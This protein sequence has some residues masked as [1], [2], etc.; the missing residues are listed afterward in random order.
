MEKKGFK[1]H[2]ETYS[3]VIPE[4]EKSMCNNHNA[5]KLANSCGEKSAAVTGVGAIVCGCHNMK[6]PLSIGDLKK[7]E[8]YLNMDYSILSTLSYDTPPDLVISYDIAC[9]W[10]KNFFTY[11]EKYMASSRLHQSKC[12]ILYLVPKFHLPVHILSCCNN[13]S[14]N[15]LAKVGWTD[16]DAP[17]WGWAATNALANSTKEMGQGSHWDTLDDHFGNYN[18][19]KIIIIALIICERYKDTVAARAQHIA[20]FISYKDTLWANH[21]TILHQWR[22]MVLAWESDHTQP[23][24]FS[25]TLHLIKNTV[26]LELA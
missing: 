20:K 6:H 24:P 1:V 21:L 14:F 4:E 18:W 7:G 15:F 23:N 25:P 2:L 9:Q 16:S 19:Q 10:H 17:E 11:M 12:N 26:Q 8:R 3:G 5:V 13:F 22:M